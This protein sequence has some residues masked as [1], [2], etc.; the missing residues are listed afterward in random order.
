M[1]LYE[2]ILAGI[3]LILFAAQLI[4]NFPAKELL[5]FL[6]ICILA[7]SYLI[8]GFWLLNPKNRKKYFIPIA[9]GL[10]FA[11]SLLVL[12]FTVNINRDAAFEILPL[13]N[14]ALFFSLGI[15]L[16]VKRNDSMIVERYRGIFIRSAVILLVVGFFSYL[17]ISSEIYRNVLIAMNSGNKH[18]VSNVLM[19]DYKE[20]F[21][22]AMENGN[23]DRAIIYAEKANEAGK[24]WLDISS[25]EEEHAMDLETTFRMLSEDSSINL[26]PEIEGK[27]EA[28]QYHTDL[29]PISGT[30][31]SLYRAYKCKADEYY[32]SHEYEQALHYYLKADKALNACNHNSEYWEM[33]QAHS[34]NHIGLCHQK[35][36]NYDHA[37]SLFVQAI[38]RYKKVK[39][40]ADQAMAVFF[41]NLAGSLAEQRH[42]AYSNL[43]YKAAISVLQNDT[44]EDN[45]DEIVRSY[46][47]IIKNHL[48]ADSLD[49]AVYLT[50]EIL[51]QVDR[52]SAAYCNANLYHGVA[53]YKLS[54]Y[55]KA[56]EIFSNCLEC[57]ERIQGKQSQ[58]IAEVHLAQT[59]VKIALAEFKSAESHIEKGMK[60]TAANNGE[61]SVKMAAYLEAYAVLNKQMANYQQSQQLYQQVFEIYINKMGIRNHQL[62]E[63]LSGLADLN[64]I[65]AKYSDA[66]ARSDSSMAIA[67]FYG[68]LSSPASTLLL[69]DAAHVNYHVGLYHVSDSLYRKS[70]RINRNYGLHST[71]LYADALNGLGLVMTAR[72]KYIGADS[73][74]IHSLKL[75]KEIFTDNHPY[76]ANVFLNYAHLKINE[77]KLQQAGE[78]LDKS[79]NI[80]KRFFDQSH[81]VFADIYAARGDLSR[82]K[83]HYEKAKA[84]Y[85]KALK[86]YRGKFSEEHAR[87]KSIKDRLR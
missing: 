68:G 24:R 40:T 61:S 31:T 76:T 48:Q 5:F 66:K 11:S 72:G 1:R 28:A 41:T 44:T 10:A 64:I 2:K 45:N 60:I 19:F 73:L 83:G 38:E 25:E 29:Y 32:G 37:D 82:K 3:V 67:E 77:N 14:A 42:F 21:E 87:V 52:K 27:I 63:V 51:K 65:L 18:T 62:P 23:C 43:I 85:S 75:H 80:N 46:F 47:G 13:L 16:L 9:A 39:N 55:H 86:I 70:L 74:F 57:Y 53:Y 34:L 20:E 6:S 17:P 30:Y 15:Y 56:G 7:L 54:R 4:P 58:N 8:G 12:P 50:E 22:H 71:A 69:N 33:E 78:L 79:R 49:K 36:Y 35:L 81:D 26:S 59:M 84:Y